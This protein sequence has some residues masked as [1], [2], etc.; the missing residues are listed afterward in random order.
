MGNTFTQGKLRTLGR[1]LVVLFVLAWMNL[2]FQIPAHAA[3]KQ[4]MQKHA[5]MGY[6]CPCQPGLCDSVIS[7]ADQSL[8]GMQQISAQSLAFVAVFSMPL[9]QNP[10]ASLSTRPSFSRYSA[11]EH[12]P[13][14]H[15]HKNVLRI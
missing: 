2:S 15:Q 10:L 13:P 9:M 7:T 3:M 12:R 5:A 6:H 14:P 1:W 8:N 4:V 11:P